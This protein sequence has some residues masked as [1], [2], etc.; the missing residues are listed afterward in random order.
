[1][2]GVIVGAGRIGF[3]LAKSMAENHDITIIDKD[4]STCQKVDGILDCYVIQGT[5]T[6]TKILEEADVSKSD[7]FVAA[8]GNDEVNLLSSVYAKEHGVK[9]IVSRLNNTEHEDIF[10]KLNIRVVN[11][12][13]SAMRFIARNIV[14]PT[15]QSLVSIGEGDAEIIELTVKN[16]DVFFT[17]IIEVENNSPKFKIVTVYSGNEVIIPTDNTEIGYDDSIAVLVK[18]EYIDEIREYFTRNS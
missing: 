6:N 4:K 3:N 14:R 10:K 17:P 5:G 11:P 1:M 16:N 7:F 12:E 18:R 2:I 15:A 9:K 8:T 13:R